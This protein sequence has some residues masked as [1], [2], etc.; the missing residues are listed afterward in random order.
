MNQGKYGFL[1][2]H[3]IGV[4]MK[5]MVRRAIETVRAELLVFET[6][7]KIGHSGKMDDLVTSADEKAQRVYEKIILEGLPEFGIIAEEDNLRVPCRHESL[8]IYFT[9]DPVDGTK[10]LA[11]RQ[12]HGIGTMLGLVC[13]EE[14]IAAYVGDIMTREIFGFRPN[15]PHVHRISEY[16]KSENLRIDPERTLASQYLLLKE[17]PETYPLLL[18]KMGLKQGG[19]FKTIEVSGGSIGIAAARLWKGEIGGMLLS[20]AIVTPWDETP[21]VGISQ[22][23]GFLFFRYDS[24]S[25]ALEKWQPPI[26]KEKYRRNESL[27]VVHESRED[28]LHQWMKG[29]EEK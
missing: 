16:E 7:T 13:N 21:V 12:S 22:K 28:E 6:K 10:A 4:V 26:A 1:N 23:M 27:L 20:S 15:S 9:I 2:D 25:H 14:V 24:S 11:R 8:D 3:L 29:K 18:Q 17:A 19:L 5:E